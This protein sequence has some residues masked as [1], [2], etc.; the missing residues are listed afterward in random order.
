[1]TQY[2]ISR[3]VLSSGAAGAVVLSVAAAGAVPASAASDALGHG[4]KAEVPARSVAAALRLMS[5]EEKVGQLF[6]QNVYGS[7]ATT[8]DARNIPLYGVASPA[9]VVRKYHLGGVIYFAWTDSVKDPAQI[10]ALSNGLQRA[11]IGSGA[12]IPLT[13]GTDQEQGVVT[14]IGPPATQ[15]PGSMALG[16]SRSTADARTAAAITGRE[17]KAMGINVDYAPDADVNVNPLNPVIGTRS[18]SSDPA[19]VSSMVAAQVQ[20]YQHDAGV[21]ASPKHFPGHGDTATDSHTG[22][23]VITHT[24]AQWER[25]DAPP[26]RAAIRAGTDMIMSGHLVVPALDPSGDPATLSK[27]ILT[28]ILREELGYRG[29][30]V[31]DSL[32]MQGVRD[33]Y[34]DGEVA[35]RAVLAGVDTLLMAPDMDAAY[36]SV[37]AAVTSGRISPKR[38]D[39][40]VARILLMKLKRGILF[41]PYADASRL[42]KV[43]GTPENLAAADTI[44]NRTTTVLR[45]DDATLPLRAS[46]HKVLVTGYGATT[47]TTLAGGLTGRGFTVT[48]RETGAAPGDAAIADAVAKAAG[49][50]EVVVTTMKAWDTAVTDRAAGQQRLVKALVAT[51]V[52]VVV[53][54]VRDPYDIAYLPGVRTYLATYSYSPVAIEAAVRV[55][56]G[57]VGPSGTLPVDV[58]VAGQPS[59]PLYPFGSG[60][61]W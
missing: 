40:S 60:I 19:L 56:T 35:V 57:E 43:V 34:G 11:A 20:G 61:T 44:S 28:G 16:A 17:L 7:D 21:V 48:R 41:A 18:F 26:F 6:V 8:P 1:M 47:T 54:A 14:R 36:G 33:R 12:H 55:I 24:R 52:P 49:Q 9:D 58:P 2:L 45:N 37:L 23:P 30:I 31:T 10:T 39:E 3:R 53:V 22:I 5:T 50:D 32:A 29:V 51:G 42:D 59:T 4:R 27:P 38:L 15:F 25:T 46:G 13:V